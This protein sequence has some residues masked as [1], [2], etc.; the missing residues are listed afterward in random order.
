MHRLPG[1]R[2]TA[3][4]RREETWQ[5]SLDAV[6]PELEAAGLAERVASGR[7]EEVR[8]LVRDPALD[9]ELRRRVAETGARRVRWYWE[10]EGNGERSRTSD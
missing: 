10:L 4:R 5:Y 7:T 3:L 2:S 6:R 1:T 8:R 9:P